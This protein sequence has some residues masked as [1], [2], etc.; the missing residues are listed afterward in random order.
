MGNFGKVRIWTVFLD[1]KER[2]VGEVILKFFSFDF[3]HSKKKSCFK[4]AHPL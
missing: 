2:N 1:K 4:L 3:F